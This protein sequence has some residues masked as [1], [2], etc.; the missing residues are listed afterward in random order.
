[1]TARGKR[2]AILASYAPSLVNFRGELL[3]EI[4]AAGA[5]VLALAPEFDRPTEE[6]LKRE[7]I[8]CRTV[9]LERTGLNPFADLRTLRNLTAIFRNW[10][11]DVVTGYTPKA[12]I[13]SALAAD[14]AGVPHIAP[15]V[16]GLG[17]AFLKEP[18]LKLALVRQVTK[19]LYRSAFRVSHA[20][21]FHNDDDRRQ[22]QGLGLVPRHLALHVVGGS[23]VDLRQF[24][25]QPLP[26]LNDGLTFL[27][28]ARLVRYKGI[29]EYCEAARRIRARGARATFR[30]IGP[31]E[32]GP[33][34]FG[35]SEL[36]HYAGDVAYLGPRSDIAA[37]LGS[38]HVYV[39]PSYGEGMPRT[40]LEAMAV[41]RPVI[42]T[43]AN[44]CRDTVEELVNGLKVPV[45]DTDRLVEAME[46]FLKRPDL[47]A[48]MARASR[49]RAE[50]LYDVRMVNRKTRIALQLE[51]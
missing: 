4:R 17:Y 32:G 19:Q 27:M 42:T 14:R 22:L 15:M 25:E 9:P 50:R 49:Q 51:D 46:F 41:G 3:K 24:P 12:A 21:I 26:P 39:L 44:G 36:A 47:I 35:E 48:S 2:L 20:A 33:A 40:V 45:A 6:R 31:R 5:E 10:R 16:T 1:M 23:G 13:Y 43:D 28:I 30:L 7:G 34:G 8:A 11:P 29:F 18:S 38:T 37:Q